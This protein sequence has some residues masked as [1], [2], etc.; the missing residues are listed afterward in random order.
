MDGVDSSTLP[1]ATVEKSKLHPRVCQTDMAQSFGTYLV[2]WIETPAFMTSNRRYWMLEMV[3]ETHSSS[4]LG[5][6]AIS[7]H[8]TVASRIGV[9]SREI[10]SIRLF[11]T[12]VS[13]PRSRLELLSMKMHHQLRANIDHFSV[14]EA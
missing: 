11:I 9:Y 5:S 2:R 4:R 6:V 1:L 14:S 3:F 7:R 10:R 8:S 12:M 13:I